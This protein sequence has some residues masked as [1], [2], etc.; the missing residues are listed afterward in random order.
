VLGGIT[1]GIFEALAGT[2][3]SS[4]LKDMISYSILIAVILI[5][6]QGLM[7]VLMIRKV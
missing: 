7:G 4:A 2:Y 6:P 5:R 1:L 3:I